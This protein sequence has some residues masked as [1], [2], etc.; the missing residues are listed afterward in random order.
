[1]YREG[2]S[3]REDGRESREMKVCG[4]ERRGSKVRVEGEKESVTGREEKIERGEESGEETKGG[5]EKGS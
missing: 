5:K 3:Q 1:M 2:G 4:E